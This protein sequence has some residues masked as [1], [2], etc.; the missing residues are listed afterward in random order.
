MNKD[1][2]LCLLITSIIVLVVVVFLIKKRK[3]NI[4]FSMV[5]IIWG[6]VMIL[7]S[8]FPGIIFSIRNL[9]GI[10]VVSNAVFLIAIFFLYCLTFYIYLTISKHNEEIINLNYE[11]AKLKCII[12]SINKKN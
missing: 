2:Q 11:I 3:M 9:L 4:H 1:L 6:I 12:E 5:W 7:L 8:A 10:E